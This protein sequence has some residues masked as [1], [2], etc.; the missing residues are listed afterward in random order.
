M[1]PQ[2]RTGHWLTQD[3]STFEVQRFVGEIV[4]LPR[5]LCRAQLIGPCI[6]QHRSPSRGRPAGE[7]R[8]GRRPPLVPRT[9]RAGSASATSRHLT[10]QRVRSLVSQVPSSALFRI[11]AS[12]SGAC[13][14]SRS[15]CGRRGSE[16]FQYMRRFG[17]AAD[18]SMP[19]N[20]GAQARGWRTLNVAPMA[21]GRDL[22]AS[23]LVET[24][25]HRPSMRRT[26]VARPRL[27]ARL[28]TADHARLLLVSAP[29]GFGKTT[30]VT[31]WLSALADD[32]VVAWLSLDEGDNDPARFWT[33]LLARLHA[34]LPGLGTGAGEL[35]EGATAPTDAV[36]ATLINELNMVGHDVVLVLDD[37]P[38][39]R[40]SRRSTRVVRFCSTTCPSAC[41]SWS[42]SRAD[43]PLP[44]PRLRAARRAPRGPGRRPA[45]H[46][47]RGG[48]I[49]ERRDGP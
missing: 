21:E 26:L 12:P 30:L 35:L 34:A 43:P 45:L 27:H 7:D 2:V 16:G 37:Y 44:L 13:T 48:G 14:L 8:C 39:H 6:T 9:A 36:L 40:S 31:E 1:S 20:R 17:G 18:T 19:H 23:P 38:R 29:A 46:R 42:P 32:T 47:R 10:G 49:P 3:M 5:V 4:L 33:Y 28:A 15:I 22:V 11:E 24:K 41:V 25:I